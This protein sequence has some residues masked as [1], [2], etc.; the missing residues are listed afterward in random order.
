ML[1][2]ELALDVM[3]DPFQTRSHAIVLSVAG[4]PHRVTPLHPGP[5]PS[6]L[7]MIGRALTVPSRRAALRRR[8]RE[9]HARPGAPAR[10]RPR[11]RRG[12]QRRGVHGRQAAGAAYVIWLGIQAIRHRGDARAAMSGVA[13]ARASRRCLRDRLPGRGHQPEDDRVLRRL[14]AAVRQRRRATGLQMALLG[15]VFGVIELSPTASGRWP[16]PG[17][18]TGSPA[19]RTPGRPGRHRR[20]DDDQARRHP[21]GDRVDRPAT[22]GAAAMSRVR[23]HNF[24]VSLDGFGTGA[25]QSAE[26]HFGHAGDRLHPWMFATRWW[27][28]G[29]S[30][31]VDDVFVRQHDPGS[32][33]RS[34]VPASGAT[35]AGRTTRTGRAPGATTRRSTRRSSS[36]PTTAARRSRWPVARRT[37]S[38]TPRLPMRSSGPVQAADGQDVRIGGGP[39]I[40]RDFL[41]ARLVDHAHVVVVPILLGRGVPAL[42]RPRGHRGRLPHSRPPRHPVASRTSRS[43][44]LELYQPRAAVMRGPIHRQVP[45][46]CGCRAI[47]RWSWR[48]GGRGGVGRDCKPCALVVIPEVRRGLRGLGTHI[49]SFSSVDVALPRLPSLGLALHAPGPRMPSKNFRGS[50]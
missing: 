22:Q 1:R 43:L 27:E 13:S 11:C 3:S 18:G 21:G 25:G 4:L 35:P 9:G 32:A 26:A 20:R 36:S 8:Q 5:G 17:P 39:T 42:G 28:D 15:L 40:V 47:V 49:A 12:G 41:A 45:W 7:F 19:A 44:A 37:I 10:G 24:A 16:P 50:H 23:V 30:G 6:L 31:G 34:W 38:S 46:A 33:P 29:G 2:P 48:C 14:P